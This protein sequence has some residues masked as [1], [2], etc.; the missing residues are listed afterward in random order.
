MNNVGGGDLRL[1]MSTYKKNILGLRH[2]YLGNHLIF[3]H[4]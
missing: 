4:L 1:L 3:E 2:F